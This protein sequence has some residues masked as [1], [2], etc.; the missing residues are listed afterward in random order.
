MSLRWFKFRVDWR[1]LYISVA[2]DEDENLGL[3]AEIESEGWHLKSQLLFY[4]LCNIH[5]S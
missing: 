4:R 5:I 1:C 3:G 2:E